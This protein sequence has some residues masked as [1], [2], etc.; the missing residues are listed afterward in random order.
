MSGPAAS[1]SG[2]TK[3]IVPGMAATKRCMAE[4]AG[5]IS[6]P[7]NVLALR[8]RKACFHFEIE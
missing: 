4:G 5:L 1:V 7:R 3:K 2:N 6:H 8:V